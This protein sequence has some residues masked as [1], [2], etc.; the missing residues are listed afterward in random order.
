MHALLGKESHLENT[1]T[2]TVITFALYISP[3]KDFI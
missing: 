1:I 3:L 2:D